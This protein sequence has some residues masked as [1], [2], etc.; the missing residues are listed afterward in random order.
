MV[1]DTFSF[2]RGGRPRRTSTRVI[3]PASPSLEGFGTSSGSELRS[4]AR[5]LFDVRRV[6]STDGLDWSRIKAT[7]LTMGA[8]GRRD[9][10]T[11]SIDSIEGDP[12][13]FQQKPA[14]C[15]P[16]K[17]FATRGEVATWID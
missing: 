2:S 1:A 14:I 16:R 13:E 7:T 4:A 11:L 10:R 3:F 17:Y 9:W 5:D 12:R 6:L 8:S 15:L